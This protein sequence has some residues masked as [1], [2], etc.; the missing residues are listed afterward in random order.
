MALRPDWCDPDAYRHL[1]NLDRS[2]WIWEWLRRDPAYQEQA[3]ASARHPHANSDPSASPDSRAWGL[4]RF[5][6]PVA[7]AVHA[8]PMWTAA[9]SPYV[10]RVAVPGA[11]CPILPG[12][13]LLIT[14]MTDIAER[15]LEHLLI[16][17][18]YSSLR[19][20]CEEDCSRRV[21][22]AEFRIAVPTGF[23]G[24]MAAMG[25]VLALIRTG[26][27]VA[28]D[29]LTPARSARL[30]RLLRISDAL[31]AD[32]PQRAIAAHLFGNAAGATRWRVEHPTVRLQVQRL[33][34]NARDM[35]AGG[36]RDLF[37]R[38]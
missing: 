33:V 27:L 20:D 8:R 11:G 24:K 12:D 22:G 16:S 29:P 32:A 19:L 1:V 3:R 26:R 31:A 7:D 10:L 6:D 18:G 34:R 4:H 15:G 30:T 5:C 35:A 9:F 17:D 36:Y 37:E 38:G 28:A 13:R 14:R 21:A 25:Q 23:A 2:A